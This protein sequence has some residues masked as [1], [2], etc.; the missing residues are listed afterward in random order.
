MLEHLPEEDLLKQV[1]RY[2]KGEVVRR[3]TWACTEQSGAGRRIQAKLATA[4]GTGFGLVTQRPTQYSSNH[5]GEVQ[6][7]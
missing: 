5:I 3:M 6:S 4:E 7:K 2:Y 1:R